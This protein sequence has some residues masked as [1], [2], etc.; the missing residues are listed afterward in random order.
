MGKIVVIDFLHLTVMVS[1]QLGIVFTRTFQK[2]CVS[3][4]TLL[5]TDS[6]SSHTINTFPWGNMRKLAE[7]AL[8][9][10]FFWSN[11]RNWKIG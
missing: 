10:N 11:V 8:V 5:A 2:T 7:I 6:Q 9:I 1:E 4:T 3:N